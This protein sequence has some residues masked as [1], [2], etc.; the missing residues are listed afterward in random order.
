MIVDHSILL[1]RL[2]LRF[3]VNGQVIAWIEL[4]LM[5]PERMYR[6]RIPSHLFVNNCYLGY[7][8]PVPY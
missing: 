2:A 6:S 4:Y 5:D 8:R 1:S 3:S 7:H